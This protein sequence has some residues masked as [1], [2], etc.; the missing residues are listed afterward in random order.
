MK[1][2]AKGSLLDR[3]WPALEADFKKR[4]AKWRPAPETKTEKEAP[5]TAR[6]HRVP[7]DWQPPEPNAPVEWEGGLAEGGAEEYEVE[8]E[9]AGQ[10]ARITGTVT[11]RFLQQIATDGL[12]HWN[13]ERIERRRPAIRA[14]LAGSGIDPSELAEAEARTIEALLAAITEDTGRWILSSHADARTELAL[15]VWGPDGPETHIIDRSFVDDKGTCWII[16]Y[17]T[18][19]RAGGDIEGFLAQELERH[20]PKLRRYREVMGEMEKRA[21]KTALYYPLLK[22]FREV[23]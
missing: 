12:D 14:M 1:A 17:K 16:D 5:P 19:Y 23:V 8:Y 13:E 11:H 18:G 20:G 21:I 22:A 4:F 9:W 3:L 6:L 15:A 2:P 7:T 10:T